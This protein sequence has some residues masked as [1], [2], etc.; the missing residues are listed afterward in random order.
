MQQFQWKSCQSPGL[1][2]TGFSW[3]LMPSKGRQGGSRRGCSLALLKP[4]CDR[5]SHNQDL[6]Q[7]YHITFIWQSCHFALWAW[8]SPMMGRMAAKPRS[9]HDVTTLSHC[10]GTSWGMN[11]P[12]VN[13]INPG[14]NCRGSGQCPGNC[15][16]KAQWWQVHNAAAQSLWPA[17]NK[18]E[19]RVGSWADEL[20]LPRLLHSSSCQWTGV[21]VLHNI[22]LQCLLICP[23]LFLWPS[24]CARLFT[25]I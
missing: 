11:G 6:L 24:L 9:V 19:H 7:H 15:T 4:V 20:R 8:G 1:P 23:L 17:G 12:V 14:N 10:L 5:K 22:S 16:P 2:G 13:G 18:T 3:W 25:Y 21:A